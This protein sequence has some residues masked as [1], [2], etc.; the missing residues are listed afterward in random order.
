[1]SCLEKGWF[2]SSVLSSPSGSP[3]LGSPW[4]ARWVLSTGHWSWW[5]S[6]EWTSGWLEQEWLSGWSLVKKWSQSGWGKGKTKRLLRSRMGSFLQG[7]GGLPGPAE[8]QHKQVIR[9]D[10]QE[11]SVF[12]TGN[13]QN[14]WKH[15]GKCQASNRLWVLKGLIFPPLLKPRAELPS[16]SFELI[17][18]FF[19]MKKMSNGPFSV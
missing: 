14:R 6:P 16:W 18:L 15:L 5:V 9:R 8:I 4:A 2:P 11:G 1:M 3:A 19:C 12:Y 17:F 13:S 7:L 10:T